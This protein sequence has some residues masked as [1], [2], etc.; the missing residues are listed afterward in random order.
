MISTEVSS[1]ATHNTAA[2]KALGAM[3]FLSALSLQ[4]T[5]SSLAITLVADSLGLRDGMVGHSRQSD[6][7][8]MI[9]VACLR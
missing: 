1:L 3:L 2:V 5:A 7:S 9:Y 4:I 8:V 6:G